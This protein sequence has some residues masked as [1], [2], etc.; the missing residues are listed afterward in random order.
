MKDTEKPVAMNAGGVS[1]NDKWRAPKDDCVKVRIKKQKRDGIVD[2]ED[3][4]VINLVLFVFVSYKS[5]LFAM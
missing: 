3:D 2:E 1:M 5:L 4:E